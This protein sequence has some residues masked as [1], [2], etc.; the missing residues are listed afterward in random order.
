MGS[1]GR[2]DDSPFTPR[3][4]FPYMQIIAVLNIFENQG[5]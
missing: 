5:R 3:P 4:L 1:T 2:P